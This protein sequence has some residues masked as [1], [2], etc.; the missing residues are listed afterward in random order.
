MYYFVYYTVK[1]KIFVSSIFG[2]NLRYLSQ[3]IREINETTYIYENP[4]HLTSVLLNS[5]IY[6]SYNSIYTNQL[7]SEEAS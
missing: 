7:A 2:G 6:F 4:F 1:W 5:Y 3:D